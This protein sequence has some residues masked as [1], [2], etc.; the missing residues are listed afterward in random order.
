MPAVLTA[1]LG[2]LVAQTADGI[3]DEMKL[4][5]P[6]DLRIRDQDIVAR[7][8]PICTEAA[9]EN[10]I[11]NGVAVNTELS[12]DLTGSP[13]P[14]IIGRAFQAGT[15]SGALSSCIKAAGET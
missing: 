11:A 13:E 14:L 6:L 10:P 4:L 2:F 9:D 7:Q 3:K 8:A 12:D 15:S 1:L 5:G